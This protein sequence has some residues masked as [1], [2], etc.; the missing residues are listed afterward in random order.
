MV[1]LCKFIN[2]QRLGSSTYHGYCNEGHYRKGQE[3]AKKEGVDLL[4]FDWLDE[5]NAMMEACKK[6]DKETQTDFNELD[7]AIA[8]LE[9]FKKETEAASHNQQNSESLRK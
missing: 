7:Q 8:I 6:V 9:K 1:Q 3:M 5:A 2:C 4:D